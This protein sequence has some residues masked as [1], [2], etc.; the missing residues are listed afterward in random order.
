MKFLICYFLDEMDSNPFVVDE[1]KSKKR[2]LENTNSP[3]K[4]LKYLKQLTK[5]GKNLGLA[6]IIE[7]KIGVSVK[8]LC[9]SKDTQVRE[10]ANFLSQQWLEYMKEYN[11]NVNKSTPSVKKE[12]KSEIKIEVKKEFTN[13]SKTIKNPDVKTEFPTEVTK[14]NEK[15]SKVQKDK[16]SKIKE[17]SKKSKRKTTP[18]ESDGLFMALSSKP[19]K[20]KVQPENIYYES[21]PDTPDST[22]YEKFFKN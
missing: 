5:A 8:K 7:S 1:L 10:A 2:K 18:L 17:K 21:D 4:H 16:S 22:A 9:S 12:Y 20:Q 13:S 3:E 19:K 15:R 11:E 6:N 14:D